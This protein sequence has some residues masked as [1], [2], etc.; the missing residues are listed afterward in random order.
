MPAICLHLPSCLTTLLNNNNNNNNTQ[1][2][3]S[4]ASANTHTDTKHLHTHTETSRIAIWGKTIRKLWCVFDPCVVYC[5]R[6]DFLALH[7]PSIFRIFP[8]VS[9][10]P[11]ERS[12]W[13]TRFDSNF[14]G[15]KWLVGSDNCTGAR[16][17][18]IRKCYT[19]IHIFVILVAKLYV[20]MYDTR[21]FS[22]KPNRLYI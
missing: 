11:R 15:Y 19:V 18:E 2:M 21:H 3:I 22:T 9:H 20:C 13:A 17:S 16:A 8:A 1:L 4:L 10:P 5:S 14:P 6:I 7:F 12:F